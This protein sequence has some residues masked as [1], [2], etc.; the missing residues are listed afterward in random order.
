MKNIRKGGCLCGATRYE[1]NLEGHE[2]GNCHCTMCQK[3]GGAP[4]QTF[5]D[6]P[7]EN[8]KWLTEPNGR[9]D[10]SK[11]SWRMFCKDCGSPISFRSE[12]EVDSVSF[13]TATLDDPSGLMASY[14]IYTRSRLEG[15]LP[16]EGAKQ[17]DEGG[18]F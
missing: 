10:S 3:H 13:T 2:T 9:V 14:E 5:T 18:I 17:F 15:V 16:V 11:K 8:F 4:Y 6:V 1:V 12:G 7:V